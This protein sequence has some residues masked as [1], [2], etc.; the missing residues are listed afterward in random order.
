MRAKLLGILAANLLR[1]IRLTLRWEA[2]GLE[3]DGRHWINGD[4]CILVFWHSDQLF[5]PW[6]VKTPGRQKQIHA[7]I[8]LHND[9]RIAAAGMEALGIAVIGGSSSK[10]GARALIAMK[11]ILAQGEHVGITPDGPTGPARVA[12]VGAVKL[13]S[14]SGA[15]LFPVTIIAEN[16]WVFKS[17]DKM[18]LPKPFSKV[19]V[20]CQLPYSVPP[21][22]TDEQLE[23]EAEKL[24]GILNKPLEQS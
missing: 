15:K 16:A 8:S 10:G 5:M 18:F 19:R 13:A 9:G 21:G 24:T 2:T 1:L 11:N 14:I 12:K 7:L 20:I 4:A 22:L 3:V 17:W 6:V 23:V